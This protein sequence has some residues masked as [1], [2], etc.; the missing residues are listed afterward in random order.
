MNALLQWQ[1]SFYSG[2]SVI[3]RWKVT[4]D[5][6]PRYISEVDGALNRGE[7]VAIVGYVGYTSGLE[8][9]V[10]DRRGLVEFDGKYFVFVGADR[11]LLTR[12][13]FRLTDTE[14][15]RSAVP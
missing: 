15:S 8:N 3:A 12:L 7:P 14:P 6:Y 2:E 11:Q 1:I 4:D 5:R 10:A 13:G 9:L